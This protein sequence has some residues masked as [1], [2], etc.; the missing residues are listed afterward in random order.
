MSSNLSNSELYSKVIQLLNKARNSVI[1]TVNQTMVLTYF[2]IG[3]II[4]EEEQN[5][6]DKATYGKAVIKEL[7]ERLTKEFGKG[8][9]TTNVKQ[10]RS[11]YI[12]YQNHQ[13]LSYEFNLGWSHYLKLMRIDNE[14]ERKSYEIEAVKNN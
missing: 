6:K 3:R 2:E 14:D 12:C 1:H 7:A 5:G 9:S 4:I 13:T 8:F 11:F 10:M